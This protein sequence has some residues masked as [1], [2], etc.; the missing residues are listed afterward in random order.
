MSFSF[1]WQQQGLAK[2]DFDLLAFEFSQVV[3]S[4]ITCEKVHFFCGP[5][6]D[7][8]VE[9]SR[10]Q[11]AM[12]QVRNTQKSIYLDSV[13]EVF[14]PLAT[15]GDSV[16]V[17]LEGVAHLAVHPVGWL[18]AQVE[19]ISREME[20]L[21]QWAIDPMTGLISGHCFLQR[22]NGVAGHGQSAQRAG[23]LV[24]LE[25]Y[26]RSRD[27]GQAMLYISK[28]GA[29][30]DTLIGHLSAPCHFGAGIFGLFWHGV[31]QDYS[32]KMADM[33]LRWLK[34]ENIAK[35]HVGLVFLGNRA[36]E[37]GNGNQALDQAWEALTIAR[38]RGPYSLC[39]HDSLIGRVDH[40]LASPPRPLILALRRLWR[41]QDCFSLVLLQLSQG[42]DSGEF[43]ARIS[44]LAGSGATILPLNGRR[45]YL[46]LNQCGEQDA[47]AWCNGF[48]ERMKNLDFTVSM[49]AACYPSHHFKK[50]EMVANAGK[51][52][53]HAQFL[54]PDSLVLFDGVSLNISGD[55][56]YN[57][58]DLAGALREYRR[59]IAIDSENINLL[60][61]LG[62]TLAQMNRYHQALPLFEKVLSLDPYNFMAL[63][64]L[65]L[66]YQ[67][68]GEDEAALQR[69]EEALGVDSGSFGLLLQLGKMYCRHGRYEDAV[70]VL[71]Q[72]VNTDSS[73]SGVGHG[74]AYHY[75]GQACAGL[76][77][78][79]EA[80]GHLQRAINHNPRD[81]ASLSLLGE[82]YDCED[83][84]GS[85]ALS[86]C[87]QAVGLD[88]SR[89]Q[90]WLRLG[91]VQLNQED[92]AGATA[93]FEH[94]LRLDRK[95]SELYYQ[96]GLALAGQGDGRKM[97]EKALSLDSSHKG[98][99]EAL[100]G[101]RLS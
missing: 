36:G 58:G 46:F 86:L 31:D 7:G 35:V 88:G 97:F 80:M 90:Y 28:A 98:A 25:M 79:H 93:S 68:R 61:S 54:G 74:S 77:R 81:A 87:R 30:L 73:G 24:M 95:N 63:F 56:Y 32:L 48:R 13:Q 55:I 83:Q 6:H 17:V 49:G 33:L 8:E 1:N 37:A 64:N 94:G 99:A 43:S 53:V 44:A 2:N 89:W 47:L 85:I 65:G 66:A 96:L 14:I 50:S 29:Y 84:G 67:A 12:D 70:Q 69:F 92:A 38:K 26:P 51:A 9:H 91:R 57:E 76:G 40:P 45:A 20:F 22:M 59:G 100:T 23:A 42:E 71:L 78:N 39:T 82:L 62:V 5:G 21:K 11:D 72:G 15:A 101:R 4:F 18:A 27:A 52:L 60:N 3:Q 41:N 10:W 19:R 34:R 16:V 75:L